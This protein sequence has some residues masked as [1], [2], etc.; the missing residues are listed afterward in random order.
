[1]RRAFPFLAVLLCALPVR[2][3]PAESNCAVPSELV[4]DDP[5]LPAVAQAFQAR[6]PVTIVA[7]GGASTAGTAAGGGEE[8]AYPHR[9]EDALRQRHP[10]VSITVLN[11]G[12][13]RQTAGDMVGRFAADVYPYHPTLVI[14]ETGTVEAVRGLDPE[15][16]AAQLQAGIADLRAHQTEVMMMDMQY[17][18]STT[19]V[20][21][22]EPYL[23]AL[24][25]TADV[26][27][28]YLFRRYEMMHYW[29]ENGV[30]DFVDVPKDRRAALA[31]EVYKCL[32]ERLADAI[33]YAI[34]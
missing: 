28:A 21:N 12:V 15:A 14:W 27:D 3:A 4:E 24:H 7:I 11:K 2:G 25:R 6:R 13:A 20:I 22:Y 5:K 18:R 30:F 17:S 31:T 1:M 32:A 19:S 29:G 23:D 26:E 34:R 16:F 33:D 8:N 10:G 9:L